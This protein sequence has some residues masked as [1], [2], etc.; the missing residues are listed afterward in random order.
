MTNYRI[1]DL[2]KKIVHHK[3]MYYEG[4]PEISDNEY[5]LLEEELKKLDPQNY[6]L[7]LVG[8]ILK[9]EEKKNKVLHQKKMLSLDKTYDI[10]ELKKWVGDKEVV[11]TYKLD[12]VSCSLMYRKGKLY[13]AKTRGDGTLGED[14][15][16]KILWIDS[17]PKYLQ[18]SLDLEVRGELYCEMENFL[19]L[20][21]E[22][23]AKGLERP[24]SQRNIVAGLMGRKDHLELCHHLQ[25]MAFD[26]LTT[27]IDSLA[28][29]NIKSELDKYVFLKSVLF[30]IPEALV[31]TDWKSVE[32]I[33][34]ETQSFMSAGNYQ[35]DGV[36]FT[37]NQLELQ[38]KLG[39]TNHHPRYKLAFKF[40]GEERVSTV[41]NIEWSVSRNGILTPVAEI[42]PVI[43]SGAEISRVTLHNWGIVKQFGIRAGDK[44][45][46]VRSGEVIPKFVEVVSSSSVQHEDIEYPK[47]CPSC[48]QATLV[49]EIRL[50]CENKF[51][52]ERNRDQILNFIQKIGIEDLSV[53]RLEELMRANLVKEIPDL[54][55]I[56]KDDL[57]SLDKVKDKLASK[58]LAS[59]AKTKNVDLVVFLS[60]LGLTGGAYNK[61]EKVVRSGFDT[62]EKIKNLTES[63]LIK[64]D[65]FAEKSSKEFVSSLREKLE[66]IEKLL[67]H[68]IVIIKVDK[69]K[70]GISGKIFC[71]TG[72]LSIS[73][74]QAEKIIRENGGLIVD[75][76]SKK[77][78]FLIT[79][80]KNSNSTK[81]KKAKERGTSIISEEEFMKLLKS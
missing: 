72:E 68:G 39:V 5:D 55:R 26:L 79:N 11:S 64:I 23:Q 4:K 53:K 48:G 49:K 58:L 73:R 47:E 38:E 40:R 25:F 20:A 57:L 60:S 28:S 3:L 31:N 13:L 16:D 15:T 7:D 43:L 44:I 66:L 62:L 21:N 69:K 19:K 24:M 27:T 14:V 35:I 76:V 67:A 12:G 45:R 77:V 41:K 10:D 63:Q 80:N 71:I 9:G 59:I 8:T 65:S 34:S 6:V 42:E 1:R 81:L 56:T 36:V 46:I 74:D 22:M 70:G 37:Y 75:S 50:V 52:P 51:C 61:C 2:E 32:N 54:Y 17:I 30:D 33:L 29:L 78:D 18:S